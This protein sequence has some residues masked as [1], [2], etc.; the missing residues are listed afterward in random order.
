MRRL[1][2]EAQKLGIQCDVI[3]PLD[4]QV[5]I[6]GP[7]S[8]ILVG[9]TPIPH[10]DA[11]LPRI[12]ASITDYGLAVVRHFEAM[13]M[14][15][16][17]RAQA[18]GDSRDKLRSLQILIQAGIA[19]PPSVLTRT[20]RGIRMA[21]GIV[22]GL[23]TVLKVLRGS[24]GV[25]VMIVNSPESLGSVLDTLRSLD[26]DVLLQKY[27]AEGAGTDYRVFVIGGKVVATMERKAAAGE[28]RANIHRGG[29]GRTIQLPKNFERTAIRAAKVLG[30][31][32][33]GVDL[34]PSDQGP[35]VLEVN[36]S[37]GFE[38]IEAATGLNIAKQIIQH[39][40]KGRSKK[41]RK[42]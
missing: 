35:L 31:E 7:S 40:K 25:G 24:Q 1:R 11:V 15:V 17:N 5:V 4:C 2:Q 30:L 13:K 36:S 23:P 10:Y 8:R 37:P 21:V 12:G 34:I 33:A 41:S 22:N 32:I 38:G 14:K 26:Q 19:V 6:D 39:L 20:P 3:N 28:F 27:I 18:I 42:R 29:A 9:S 16:V